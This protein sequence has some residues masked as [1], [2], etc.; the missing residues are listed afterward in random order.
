M[1]S[2]LGVI[3]RHALKSINHL[4]FTD[5]GKAMFNVHNNV[6][7]IWQ[8]LSIFLQKHNLK[9]VLGSYDK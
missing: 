6:V 3:Y 5:F 2:R 8:S 4:W 1:T 7:Y 9:V